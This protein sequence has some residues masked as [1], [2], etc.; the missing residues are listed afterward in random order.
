MTSNPE[1]RPKAQCKLSD[2]EFQ[3][4]HSHIVNGAESNK[5]RENQRRGDSG[6]G[7]VTV[8]S[9]RALATSLLSSSRGSG[10]MTAIISATHPGGSLNV[11]EAR[12]PMEHWRP[13][14]SVSI[15]IDTS[16]LA[17][18][19]SQCI[20]LCWY[21]EL[22]A[23]LSSKIHRVLTSRVTYKNKQLN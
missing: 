4:I 19:W 16:M 6:A 5:Q 15:S 23:R 12:S 21:A 18:R 10:N 9:S 8:D 2:V 22:I 20:V 13:K 14:T 7:P 1:I 3:R 17:R 11:R